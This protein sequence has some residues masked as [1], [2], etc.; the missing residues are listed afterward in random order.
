MDLLSTC[1]KF[2]STAFILS[3][4]LETSEVPFFNM[5]TFAAM[6]L[7]LNQVLCLRILVELNYTKIITLIL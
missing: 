6:V 5:R 4:F 2:Y 1:Q 3:A 7:V